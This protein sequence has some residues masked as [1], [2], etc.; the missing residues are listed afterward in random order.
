MSS[1]ERQ[2][3]LRR[4][5]LLKLVITQPEFTYDDY[6]N[7]TV[8]K[9]KIVDEEIRDLRD[10]FNKD[11]RILEAFFGVT[12][13][14]KPKTRNVYQLTHV[15]EEFQSL[16]LNSEWL[17]VL[18][19]L[20][21][22]QNIHLFPQS[23]MQKLTEDVQQRYGIY[24][25]VP[26]EVFEQAL[27]TAAWR[28]HD[29]I[30][31][32]IFQSLWYAQKE[33]FIIEFAYDAAREGDNELRQ[34]WVEPYR[35]YVEDGHL[36]LYGYSLKAVGPFGD[37]PQNKHFPFR[38]G[39]IAEG[40]LKVHTERYVIERKPPQFLVHYILSSRLTS[41]GAS[42]A[43]DQEYSRTELSDGRL[44]IRASTS[45]KLKAVQK[46]LRYGGQVKVLGGDEV[47][48]MYIDELEMMIRHYR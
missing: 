40:T 34:H 29:T 30:D 10:T 7:M 25:R 6:L 43:F 5:C 35:I 28:D 37:K 38:I 9:Q 33:H 11:C 20:R 16:Y 46:L 48:K 14:P 4:V 13:Q 44:E 39:R 32:H 47:L 31:P 23:L 3:L 22:P 26:S 36:Y 2:A 21:L 27:P 1:S 19:V 41:R 42:Q 18:G 24:S 15:H 8:K 17:Q 45:D 12:I